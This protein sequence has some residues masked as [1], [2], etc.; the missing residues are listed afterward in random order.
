M[1]EDHPIVIIGSGPIGLAAAAHLVARKVP[2]ILFE[3]ESQVAASVRAWGHVRLFTP[4]QYSVD[5]E[6][7]AMLEATG[8][9]MPDAVRC[10]TGHDL[11]SQYLEPLAA[12]P[13]I[14]P[15][16]WLGHR[17]TAIARYTLSKLEEDRSDDPFLV[18]YCGPD[19]N[20][21][22]ILACA[23]IDASGA[24]QSPNPLGSN[25]LHVPG[26]RQLAA[27]V[28]YGI[29][30]VNG[31]AQARYAEQRVLVVGSGHSTL[32]SLAAL[33][34]LRERAPATQVH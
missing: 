12:L 8:W 15:H 16:L 17:I 28:A 32:N 21:G 34:D 3:A 33:V 4:W 22:S 7:S 2:F 24:W 9:Q 10:P 19:G 25:G 13:T 1:H 14:A 5:P 23:I 18:E 27:H 20:Y 30:D 31:S 29:P 26:E 6:A 11:R